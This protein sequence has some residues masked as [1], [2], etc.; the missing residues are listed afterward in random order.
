MPPVPVRLQAR[1]AFSLVEMLVVIGII[2]LLLAL[3]LPAVQA[4]REAARRVACGNQL[5]QLGLAMHQHQLA[6]GFLPP[7]G[8]N[9]TDPPVAAGAGWATGGPASRDEFDWPWF[10]LPFL[11]A[12]AVSDLPDLPGHPDANDAIIFRTPIPTL[13]CPSRRPVGLS[14]NRHWGGGQVAFAKTDYAGCAGSFHTVAYL[15]DEKFFSRLDGLVVRTGAARVTLDGGVPDGASNTILLGEKRMVLPV[16]ECAN[17]NEP[18]VATGSGDFDTTRVGNR[19]FMPAPD[20]RSLD[21][22]VAFRSFGSSH[23]GGV[24][25]AMG[26]ASVRMMSY[27]VAPNV[28]EAAAGRKDRIP[29]SP[30][31]L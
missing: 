27:A 21:E 23:P 13:Y 19:H 17:D 6:H 14:T 18:Y 20:T 22:G 15:T 31:D 26:D 11:E 12:T 3:L 8:K 1:S 10:L 9:G 7:A 30:D 29:V 2:G 25:I 28:L 4:A 16:E 24:M 5:R